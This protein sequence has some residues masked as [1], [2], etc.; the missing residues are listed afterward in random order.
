[1]H[2]IKANGGHVTILHQRSFQEIHDR[3]HITRWKGWDSE[4]QQTIGRWAVYYLMG[5][6]SRIR[7]NLYNTLGEAIGQARRVAM[8]NQHATRYLARAA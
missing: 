1:M 2:S 8:F 4:T 6:Q 3:P 7:C 5:K